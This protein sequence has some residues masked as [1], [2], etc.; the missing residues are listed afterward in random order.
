MRPLRAISLRAHAIVRARPRLVIA[1]CALVG[2]GAIAGLGWWKFRAKPP[3]PA[4]APT[5]VAAQEKPLIVPAAVPAP[6]PTKVVT[7]ADGCVTAECH[8]MRGSSPWLHTPVAKGDCASCHKPDAGGHVY[9]L[10]RDKSELCTSCH[11]TTWHTP[12]QHAAMTDNACLEC[13]D[14]HA[15]LTNDLLR[16]KTVRDTCSTC[17]PRSEGLVT[18]T[19]YADDRCE[20]CHNSHGSDRRGL[21]RTASLEDNCRSCHPATADHTTGSLFSHAKV[22]GSC[23]ACHS[24]HTAPQKGM[25]TAPPRELCVSCHKDIGETIAGAKVSHDAV[26]KGERCVRCHDPHGSDRANLLRNDQ[27]AICLSCHSKEVKAADGRMVASM[28]DIANQAPGHEVKGHQECA[29][30]HSVHGGSH[31]QLLRGVAEKIPMGPYDALNFSLCFSC[32]DQ[33]LA[34]DADATQ[35]RD[36]DRNLHAVHLSPSDNKVRGCASCHAVHSVGD[37]RLIAK[38][39]NFEGSGWHM[40][41]EFTLREDGGS[42]GGACHEPLRYSRLPGGTG[43]KL[44]GGKP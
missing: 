14:P 25:L 23:L 38:T 11:D 7:F 2:V 1:L 36:G 32:H 12:V 33:A 24:P 28:A 34:T 10:V 42:C 19:P 15:A 35:F 43:A 6:R 37:P 27:A 30:C 18:H 20:L 17:H 4:P 40:P 21:L 39:I 31:A 8:A 16:A 3:E 13:H 29:G 22:E 9:P 26:L 44:K 5:P 41:M